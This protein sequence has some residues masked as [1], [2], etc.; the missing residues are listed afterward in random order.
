MLLAHQEDFN[1]PS[2]R[3]RSKQKAGA[4]LADAVDAA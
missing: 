3:R 4:W 1:Q 2:G